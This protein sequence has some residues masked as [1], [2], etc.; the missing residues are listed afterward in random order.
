M[1]IILIFQFEDGTK[2]RGHYSE[3]LIRLWDIFCSYGTESPDLILPLTLWKTY[4]CNG[5]MFVFLK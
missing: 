3:R 2:G 5:K 4:H 1:A